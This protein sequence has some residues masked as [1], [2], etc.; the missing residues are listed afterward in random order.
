MAIKNIPLHLKAITEPVKQVV[1]LPLHLAGHVASVAD[2]T[3]EQEQAAS[4]A[5][6]IDVPGEILHMG[7]GSSKQSTPADEI[8][9]AAAR[10]E[11]GISGMS[12]GEKVGIA[13]AFGAAAY[14]IYKW[15]T[16]R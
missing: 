7:D 14:G 4:A 10:A 2:A 13:A 3:A 15:I 8:E 12:T 6:S 1:N 11:A 16:K 9:N 5:P